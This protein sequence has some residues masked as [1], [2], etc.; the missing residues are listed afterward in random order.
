MS[1]QRPQGKKRNY[2][3]RFRKMLAQLTAPQRAAVERTEGP[4]LVIAGPGTGKTHILTA[5]IGKILQTTDTAPHNILCLTFT[6][7]G[8]RAMRE[9]L[10]QTIGPEAYRVHIFTFHGFCNNIIQN[11]LEVF[12]RHELEPVSEL[13]RLEMLEEILL[14]LPSDHPLRLG[15]PNQPTYYLPH[16]RDLFSKMKAES[17][18]PFDLHQAVRTYLRELPDRDDYIYRRN[19]RGY[20]A[21][22]V[23]TAKIAEQERKMKL[24]LAG[25]DLYPRYLRAME[26]RHR[27]DYDD[28]ILW[29]LEAF[30]KDPDLLRNYQEQYLYFLVDEYQDTNGAQNRILLELIEYWDEPNVFIVGDDDQ[31][32]YEFQ[33]ARLRNLEDFYSTYED[34]LATVVLTDNFRSTQPTLDGARTVIENNERRILNRLGDLGL[35]KELTAR[36]PVRQGTVEDP[37]TFR[38]T[39]RII[40]YA[41][42]TQELTDTVDHIANL[43]GKGVPAQDIAVIYARHRQATDLQLVLERRRIPFTTRRPANALDLSVLQ[44]MRQLLRYLQREV[45]E[46]Y[47]GEADLYQILHYDFLGLTPGDIARVSLL[48]RTESTGAASDAAAG[49]HWRDL[50][51]FPKLLPA[52]LDRPAAWTRLG[53]LLDSWQ[54]LVTNESPARLVERI[55]NQSGLLRRILDTQRASDGDALYAKMRLMEPLNTFLK[56]I[57]DEQQR[58]PRLTVDALLQT[59]DSMDA[60]RVRLPLLR[61]AEINPGVQLLTAHSS[62]GLEFRYV[63]LYNCTEESWGIQAGGGRSKFTLPDTITYSGEEDPEEARRRLF[64]VGLTR[65]RDQVIVSYPERDEG[66]GK[67]INRV[68]FVTELAESEGIEVEQGFV[69]TTNLLLTQEFLLLQRPELR[70]ELPKADLIDRLL[71]SFRLSISAMNTYLKCPVSFYYEY[72]LRVPSMESEAAR[73]GTIFHESLETLFLEMLR[74]EHHR[75][76]IKQSFL[77]IF[78]RILERNRAFFRAGTLD[79]LRERGR[80]ALGGYYDAHRA[81][82]TEKVNLEKRIRTEVD[83]VPIVGVIDRVDHLDVSTVHLVDYK[84]GRQYDTKTKR[85]TQKTGDKREH[86]GDYWRQLHFYKILYENWSESTKRVASGEISYLE[87]DPTGEFKTDRIEFSGADVRYVRDLIQQVHTDVRAHKFDVG[88]GEENCAWCGFLRQNPHLQSELPPASFRDLAV[89]LLDD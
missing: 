40:A 47:S 6:D 57:R 1:K 25:A 86:G 38:G 9:R 45:A 73:I 68:K 59:L 53:E 83:G 61:P 28:M 26:R 36:R 29:T 13:E 63:F 69:S 10:L 51:R 88:C 79:R 3:A 46:P 11:N 35:T 16:L 41:N 49:I 12:G 72:V 50:L 74:E 70:I 78:D 81:D 15:R 80:L 84:T 65:A 39:P 23:K 27:Y 2:E 67:S 4:V 66:K 44:Q 19:G 33:G 54:P 85:P 37:E 42:P 56:F 64:Y 30:E 52:D 75:F 5:R 55:I 8:V 62:K 18:E 24:L 20:R 14:E 21:G 76:R 32:I 31:S 71:R 87:P 58:R 17:W 43:I 89:E 7:A 82:W 48:R 22:E 77:E 60:A 34:Q